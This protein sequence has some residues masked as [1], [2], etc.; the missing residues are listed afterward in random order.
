VFNVRFLAAHAFSDNVIRQLRKILGYWIW[1][2]MKR[3][4]GAHRQTERQTEDHAQTDIDD[5][6]PG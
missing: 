1:L 5:T 3:S 4:F 6:P 2:L